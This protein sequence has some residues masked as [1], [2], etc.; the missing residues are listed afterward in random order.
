MREH[1]VLHGV[2]SVCG[3]V[4]GGTNGCTIMVD[5]MDA[6]CWLPRVCCFLQC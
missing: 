3:S 1:E 5:D 6:G 2:L 4:P